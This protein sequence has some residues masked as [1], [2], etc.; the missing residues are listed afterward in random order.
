MRKLGVVVAA[1]GL[2]AMLGVGS[3][4]GAS[5]ASGCMHRFGSQQQVSDGGGLQEWTVSE[6]R[7][8]VDPVPGYPLAGQLWEATAS[9]TAINGPSTPIIPRFNARN[10]EGGTYPVLWQL[11]S[12]RGIPSATIAEGQTATG[13]LYFDVTGTDPVTV[14]HTGG[15]TS[16]MWCCGAGMKA[17]PMKD[18]PCCTSPQPCP[19]CAGTT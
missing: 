8:S 11:A 4:A 14:T 10:A 18:C 5:A 15:S 6:L 13:T 3:A 7:K 12:P 17:M 9:V 1:L 16:L 2:M 19:C